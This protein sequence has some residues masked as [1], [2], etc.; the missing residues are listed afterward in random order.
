[1]KIPKDPRSTGRKRGRLTLMRRGVPF[2]CNNCGRSPKVFPSTYPKELRRL[3]KLADEDDRY[4]YIFLE[5]N[6]I[7]KNILDNDPINLEW[8]CKSCHKQADLKT[9]KGVSTLDDEFGYGN[10]PF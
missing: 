5:A 10:P 4:D 2:W 1:M 7:N 3:T 8:L 6:H 9:E